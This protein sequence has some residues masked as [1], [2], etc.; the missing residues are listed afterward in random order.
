MTLTAALAARRGQA[1]NR[2]HAI[3]QAIGDKYDIPSLA[4]GVHNVR[5]GTD[6]YVA[7]MIEIEAFEV[8]AAALAVKLG[9]DLPEAEPE[10]VI[11]LPFEGMHMDTL[12]VYAADRGIPF[13]THTS[14]RELLKVL[15]SQ[16]PG[17]A[18]QEP[19]LELELDYESMTIAELRDLA[20]EREID[21]GK[22]TL[23]ADIIEAI[24][25]ADDQDRE[26][27]Q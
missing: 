23:K 26:A 7:Q 15:R 21:L 3:M 17:A 1:I 4:D 8:W 22:A 25:I 16:I 20:D 2:L 11:P 5:L 19:E 12:K 9:V 6:P 10:Q 18:V 24:E 14:E 27:Q 13:T